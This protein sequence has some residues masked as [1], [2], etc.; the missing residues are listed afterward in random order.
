MVGPTS[1]SPYALGVAPLIAKVDAEHACRAL[2]HSLG[3]TSRSQEKASE[4]EERLERR[5]PRAN[6]KH[7]Q[8]SSGLRG[9]SAPDSPTLSFGAGRFGV[10]TC[11]NQVGIRM[12][13]PKCEMSLFRSLMHPESYSAT[14][15]SVQGA[16]WRSAALGQAH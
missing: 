10:H 13:W 1:T 5:L 6:P 7:S 9:A 2:L 12:L 11:Q 15:T 14:S 4:R 8:T 3:T 16:K